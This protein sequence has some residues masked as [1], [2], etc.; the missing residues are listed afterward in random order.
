VPEY[1]LR[2]PQSRASVI[3]L[4]R[5]VLGKHHSPTC[6]FLSFHGS[7]LD[8]IEKLLLFLGTAML[9]SLDVAQTF[10]AVFGGPV[11]PSNFSS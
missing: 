4:D 3:L 9:L 2:V 10:L 6:L 7:S 8:G 5:D 1:F 11:R